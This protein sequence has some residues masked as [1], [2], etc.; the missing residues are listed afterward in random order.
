[1]NANLREAGCVAAA[2][3]VS[4]VTTSPV[5]EPEDA[6]LDDKQ[7]RRAIEMATNGDLL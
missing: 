3:V 6:C 2:L 5:G 1:M 7:R 4:L